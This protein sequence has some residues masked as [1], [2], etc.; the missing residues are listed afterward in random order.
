M[1][2]YGCLSY[3]ADNVVDDFIDEKRSRWIRRLE[4]AKKN[5]ESDEV[6]EPEDGAARDGI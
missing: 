4:E 6:R 2:V 3:I 1:N 5:A